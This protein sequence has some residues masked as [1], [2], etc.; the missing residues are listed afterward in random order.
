MN[1]NE[2]DIVKDLK[3]KSSAFSD[4][5]E[6]GIDFVEKFYPNQLDFV[7]DNKEKTFDEVRS[8]IAKEFDVITQH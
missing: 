2:V 8:F 5:L 4:Y 3:E 1:K 7:L 6:N